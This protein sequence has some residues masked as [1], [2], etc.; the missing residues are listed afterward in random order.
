MNTS[1]MF[2][3][4]GAMLLLAFIPS[5]SVI[6]VTSRSAAGG[7]AHGVS[8][9]AGIVAGDII[10]I[11]VAIYGLTLLAD[12]LGSRFELVQTLGG[13]Y[14]FWLGVSLWRARPDAGSMQAETRASLLSSFLAGFL[15]T[16]AD[17]K[18]ILFYLGFFPAFLDL[19]SV[20][21][22]DTVIILVIAVLAVGG[23]KIVYAFLAARA[24]LVLQSTG[25]H[26]VINTAASGILITT[27]IF[28]IAR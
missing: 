7:F 3:L 25:M 13:V 24:S 14:L 9:A 2:A 18:A 23:A 12:V 17:H 26:R 28:L 20:S 4:F 22:A 5:V 8:V 16:L 19:N 11:L 10:F 21:W 27:G 1:S 15:V 6:T